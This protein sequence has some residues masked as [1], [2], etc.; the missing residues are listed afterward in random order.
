MEENM[1]ET[2]LLFCVLFF[3][4]FDLFFE[5]LS[6]GLG[7]VADGFFEILV[8]FY[9]IVIEYNMSFWLA[10]FAS[11]CGLFNASMSHVAYMFE[12]HLVPKTH[13]LKASTE[14]KR[15]FHEHSTINQSLTQNILRDLTN[16]NCNSQLKVGNLHLQRC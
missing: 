15:L 12:L 10:F 14:L 7:I 8:C 16:R 13:R 6:R 5:T 11:S 1:I 4:H 9:Y 3:L 2:E